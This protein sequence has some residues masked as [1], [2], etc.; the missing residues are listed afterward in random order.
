MRQRAQGLPSAAAL[1]L[2][3]Q[4]L[5]SRDG[6]PGSLLWPKNS[7]KNAIAKTS[8]GTTE[9]RSLETLCVV[10]K[11][12]YIVLLSPL[13]SGNRETRPK[14]PQLMPPPKSNESREKAT[15]QIAP[16][17]HREAGGSHMPPATEFFLKARVI[18]LFRLSA[19]FLKI[20]SLVGGR[21]VTKLSWSLGS[22]QHSEP[23]D[24]TGAS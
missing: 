20:T 4:C 22:D 11:K 19:L 17:Q 3:P 8:Q 14:T 24:M 10:K 12:T 15:R 1:T 9:T 7:H 23:D 5:S 18:T 2:R 21:E 13:L 16:G 6:I